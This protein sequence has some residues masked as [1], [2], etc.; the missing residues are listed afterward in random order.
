[1]AC[2]GHRVGTCVGVCSSGGRWYRVLVCSALP[3]WAHSILPAYLWNSVPH[4]HLQMRSLRLLEVEGPDK[5]TSG[6][7][8]HRRR[9]AWPPLLPSWPCCNRSHLELFSVSS[10]TSMPSSSPPTEGLSDLSV[11]ALKPSLYLL[12]RIICCVTLDSYLASLC[13]VLIGSMQRVAFAPL[14]LLWGWMRWF[15]SGNS[16]TGDAY[17]VLRVLATV[18]SLKKNLLEYSWFTRLY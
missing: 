10:N 9:P 12:P 4:A 11:A 8:G 13:L 7:S 5:A 2:V 17:K 18:I 3:K 16:V 1:M 6:W 15:N 14:G